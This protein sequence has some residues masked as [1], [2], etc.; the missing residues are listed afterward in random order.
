MLKV[1]GCEILRIIFRISIARGLVMLKNLFIS[2]CKMI[3]ET[4][5]KP[6]EG[7][8]AENITI[9]PQLIDLE[10]SYLPI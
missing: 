3:E 1:V 7:E 10:I 2:K 4:I 9:F 6:T 5:S 8:E